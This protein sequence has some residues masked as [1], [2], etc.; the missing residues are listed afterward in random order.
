MLKALLAA[1]R[2]HLG[3]VLRPE[4]NLLTG[5]F[6]VNTIVFSKRKRKTLPVVVEERVHNDSLSLMERM[7]GV[8]KEDADQKCIDIKPV[9][10]KQKGKKKT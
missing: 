9:T 10:K 5:S 1:A 6:R 3:V 2:E 8:T 4:I 7:L